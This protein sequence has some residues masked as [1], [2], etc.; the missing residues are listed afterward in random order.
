[1][2]NWDYN[3]QVTLIKALFDAQAKRSDLIFG[4]VSPSNARFLHIDRTNGMT[5]FGSDDNLDLCTGRVFVAYD[6]VSYG[7]TNL[8]GKVA[9]TLVGDKFHTGINPTET[10][11]GRRI[12]FDTHFSAYGVDGLLLW[13][14]YDDKNNVTEIQSIYVGAINPSVSFDT[15]ESR[16]TLTD[17]HTPRKQVNTINPG[18]S[19][20]KDSPLNPDEGKPIYQI[21]P[22]YS[23]KN[24][25]YR[26]N[27]YNPEV[28]LPKYTFADSVAAAPSNNLLAAWTIFDSMCG[29][30]VSNWGF[31]RSTWEGCLWNKLGF[32]YS[33]LHPTATDRQARHGSYY[34][35]TTQADVNT[36]QVMNWTV[37]LYGAPQYTLQLPALFAVITI[38][39][40][41]TSL[42][43]SN[44]ARQ[45]SD[46]YWL[47][48]SSL[49]ENS[50]FMDSQGLSPVIAVVDKS[51]S[52]SD[53]IYLGDSSVDFM[54]T[55]QRTLTDI[56]TS[57]HLPDGSY[58]GVN[59]RNA[60]V[61]R[62]VKPSVAPLSIIDS[63]LPQK[64]KPTT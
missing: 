9:F 3:T 58:A 23:Q 36:T 61:Y 35:L 20:A 63:F 57:L 2:T 19:S 46:G 47:I 52:S 64:K 49:I 29:V 22:L 62:I 51:Y 45:Q 13:S 48:R 27:S 50:M 26:N 12:G 41:S 59:D 11:I 37:N 15:D 14:G 56:T 38:D 28:R 60:V 53:Y 18:N 16:F 25:D 39:A 5:R 42:K 54:V 7:M 55:A 10:L 4:M 17:L 44:L 34:P 31:D 24:K 40:T 30:F 21:N 1:M 8:N 33:D 6:D 32:A 43:A